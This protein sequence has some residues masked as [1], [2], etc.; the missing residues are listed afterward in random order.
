MPRPYCVLDVFTRVALAGNPLAV[1]LDAAG[2]DDVAMQSIAQEFG[3]PETVFVLPAEHPTHSARLR[4][5]TPGRELDFAGHPT[6]GVAVAL[7]SRR[8]PELEKAIDAMIVVEENV[9]PVRCGVKLDPHG[10]HFAEFAVPRLAVPFPTD[11]GDRGSIAD[12]LGLTTADIGFENHR[13]SA[14]TCGAP[15]IFIPVSGLDAIQ[16]AIPVASRFPN[17]F[18]TANRVGVYLYTRDCVHH[19]SQFHARMF[20]PEA[21]IKEDPATGGAGRGL[22]R[23]LAEFRRPARWHARLPHRA[24]PR[25]GAPELHRPQRRYRER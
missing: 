2:L 24:R 16:R 6:V 11:F 10:P 18:G 17:A 12:A 21:G 4:I 9:G 23:R 20:A 15:F 13:P 8:F 14:W 3:L 25:D 22:R 5:F 19:D 1:V 7:A